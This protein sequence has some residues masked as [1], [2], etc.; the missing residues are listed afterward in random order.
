MGNQE[1]KLICIQ[2]PRGCHLTVT[3]EGIVT[4]NSCPKGETYARNEMLH[5]MRILTTTV[6]INSCIHSQLP[7]IT[8]DFIP[9]EKMMEVMRSLK[10]ITVQV[11][12]HYKDVIVKNV[13]DL[14]V[15]VISSRDL[16]Q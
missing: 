11:P 10:D 15:D 2:C 7:V 5:P 9:K 12:I 4:G 1:M 3:Q 6:K 16:L 8:S 14:G 13:C